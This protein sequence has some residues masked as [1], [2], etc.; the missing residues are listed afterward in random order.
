MPF[1]NAVGSFNQSISPHC[2]CA[3]HHHGLTMSCTNYEY[4]VLSASASAAAGPRLPLSAVLL[5]LAAPAFSFHAIHPSIHRVLSI[6]PIPSHP[7][8]WPC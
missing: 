3:I 7:R 2:K 5:P 8:W 6:H 1:T 4:D